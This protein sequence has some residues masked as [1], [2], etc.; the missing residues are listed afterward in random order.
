MVSRGSSGTNVYIFPISVKRYEFNIV[1]AFNL[2]NNH[3][4]DRYIIISHDLLLLPVN[5]TSMLLLHN[6]HA[7]ILTLEVFIDR[8]F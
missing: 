3:P 5:L 4:R 1:N 7:M 2:V 8:Q 6:V